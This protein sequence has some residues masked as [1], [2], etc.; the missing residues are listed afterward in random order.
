MLNL[1]YTNIFVEP[2]MACVEPAYWSMIMPYQVQQNFN[3]TMING[4]SNTTFWRATWEY[5]FYNLTD[6]I[7]DGDITIELDSGFS[8][9]MPREE[10][11]YD[12]VQINGDG[13]WDKIPGMRNRVMGS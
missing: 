11:F 4:R 1:N 3:N 2:F 7:P 12:A 8:V 9:T 10:W 5:Y 6:P 13:H